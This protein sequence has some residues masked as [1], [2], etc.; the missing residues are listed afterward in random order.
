MD[1]VIGSDRLAAAAIEASAGSRDELIRKDIAPLHKASAPFLRSDINGM[2]EMA[3]V[4]LLQATA[5][6]LPVI[7]LPITTLGRYQHQTL[8]AMKDATVEDLAGSTVGV[9]SWSQTTGVWMRGFLSEDYGVDLR[10]VSWTVYEPAHVAAF[11]DP[12]WVTRAPEGV[13]LPVEFLAGNVDFGIM[14]NE[15]PDDQRVRTVIPNPA[16]AAEEWS[17]RNGFAPINHVIAVTES[18]AKESAGTVLAA[19]DGLKSA[20]DAARQPGPVD[21]T[22]CGFDALRGPFTRAATYA[23]EQGVLHEKVDF[24]EVVERSCAALGVGR[25]RLGGRTA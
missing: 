15:L 11:T 10:D 23:F 20:I 3:I 5:Y 6:G 25:A 12:K 14:G 4:T 21:F 17:V 2:C 19:Y 24:D 1:I 9:R 13:K 16:Q 8:V 7:L 18:S 22:P